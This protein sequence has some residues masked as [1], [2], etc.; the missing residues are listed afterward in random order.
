MPSWQLELGNEISELSRS[1]PPD[2]G[3]VELCKGG[4]NGI[5]LIIVMMH[6]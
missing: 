1:A 2:E 4:K 5:F 3:L 6:W